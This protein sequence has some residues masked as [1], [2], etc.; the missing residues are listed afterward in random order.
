MSRHPVAG[1]V[2]I[3]A[4]AGIVALASAVGLRLWAT[5]AFV[6]TVT[7]DQSPLSV[8]LDPRAGRAFIAGSDDNAVGRVSVFDTR[9]GALLA[10]VPLGRGVLSPAV[11]VDE[12]AGSGQ[13]GVRQRHT[14]ALLVFL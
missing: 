4:L 2:A 12:Q 1:A 13:P 14:A 7:L 11:S 3:V 9:S 10:T 6:R 5:G 8:A